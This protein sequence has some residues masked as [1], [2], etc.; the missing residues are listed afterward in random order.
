MAGG[1]NIFVQR[2]ASVVAGLGFI[3]PGFFFMLSLSIVYAYFGTTNVYTL[4]AFRGVQPA[5]CAL[6]VRAIHKIGEHALVMDGNVDFY[7]VLV[8]VTSIIQGVKNVPFF[9]TLIVG[10]L[11]Y[12]FLTLHGRWIYLGFFLTI[13]ITIYGV[14]G[15]V[16]Y[17]YLNGYPEPLTIGGPA[18]ATPALYNIFLL[19]LLGGCLTF[20]GAYTAIPFIQ[21][22]AVINGNWLT[23]QEFIDGIALGSI[24]P[25]PLVIFV[26][27]IGFTTGFKEGLGTAFAGALLM[28]LGMFLPAFSFT[29]IGHDL[30]E[31]IISL[32]IFRKVLDGTTSSAVG[33]IVVSVMSIIRSSVTDPF[34]VVTFTV[35]LYS[36]Y[37]FKY[38]HTNIIIIIISACA[39]QI[40]YV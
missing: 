18:L 4:A 5:I 35:A 37:T 40:F 27:F 11:F 29:L 6:I 33:L 15:Y 3:L 1:P 39:G 19:G 30:Y 12:H 28:T 20:G 36:L 10:G 21:Q 26:T 31:K 38:K 16:I 32:E 17:F 8:C 13:L 22:T 2:V 9:I 25:S 7:L 34:G 23:N 24:V 14:I